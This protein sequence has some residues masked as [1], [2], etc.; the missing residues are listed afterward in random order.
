MPKRSESLQSRSTR[1][2]RRRR[3]RPALRSHDITELVRRDHKPLKALLKVLKTSK[4]D[5]EQKR[6]A[7]LKFAPMLSLHSMAIG[8]TLYTQMKTAK[9][10]R[11]QGLEGDV[12]NGIVSRLID[13]II[14]IENDNDLWMAKVKVLADVVE[15]NMNEE[16]RELLKKV[17]KK[18]SQRRR[19]EIGKEYLELLDRDPDRDDLRKGFDRSDQKQKLSGKIGVPLLLYFIGVPGFLVLMIWFVFFRGA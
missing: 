14:E 7:F 18:F 4:A 19:I 5:L 16:D 2:V 10:L 17:A 1:S 9:P 12:E 3:T 13:E 15:Q 11:V 6:S 8:E